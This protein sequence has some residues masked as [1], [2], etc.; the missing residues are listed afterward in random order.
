MG[1]ETLHG[2]LRGVFAEVRVLTPFLCSQADPRTQFMS[3][4]F[5]TIRVF[6][7]SLNESNPGLNVGDETVDNLEGAF[8]RVRDVL[9]SA[10]SSSRR[11]SCR[12]TPLSR[13]PEIPRHHPLRAHSP[14]RDPALPPLPPLPRPRRSP[15]PHSRPHSRHSRDPPRPRQ[16]HAGRDRLSQISCSQRRR[17]TS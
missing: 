1:D 12:L 13:R 7:N 11:R 8:R 14:L 6:V 10:F 3:G 4:D 16:S 15:P 17:R 2:V 9:L 5:E